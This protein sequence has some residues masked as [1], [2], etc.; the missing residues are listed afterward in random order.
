MGTK[1][2]ST[3]GISSA[4]VYVQYCLL[5]EFV[6]LEAKGS[7]YSNQLDH[8]ASF[9]SCYFSWLVRNMSAIST[10]TCSFT[11]I[12]HTKPSWSSKNYQK[13]QLS[14]PQIKLVTGLDFLI[15]LSLNAYRLLSH[16]LVILPDSLTQM[17][18]FILFTSSKEKKLLI[19]MSGIWVLW[20]GTYVLGHGDPNM[21]FCSPQFTI[22]IE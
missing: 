20:E 15:S 9:L 21:I 2:T 10:E 8:F 4:H 22:A 19:Y 11:R 7:I 14:P 17:Q 3:C 13:L 12:T 1:N 5:S 16:K 18:M 6:S